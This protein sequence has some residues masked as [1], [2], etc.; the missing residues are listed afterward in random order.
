MN[1]VALFSMLFAGFFTVAEA[2]PVQ[3]R[4]RSTATATENVAGSNTV[5][6]RAATGARTAPR[7]ATSNTSATSNAVVRGRSGTTPA[8]AKPVVAARAGTTQKVV[9]TGTKVAA[10]AKNVIVSEECQA[11]YEGCMDAF[12]MLDNKSGGRCICSDK[13]AEYDAILAEIEKLDEQSLRM[14]TVGVERLEMGDDLEAAMS[15]VKD[16]TDSLEKETQKSEVTKR[17]TLD[18]SLWNSAVDFDEEIDIFGV[19]YDAIEGKE[20]DALYVA[21][22]KMCAA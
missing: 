22:D 15:M 17:R 16:V 9:S 12:C 6:A 8:T 5:A 14:G 13:N 1:R 2:A 4:G 7:T 21:A 10:A 3:R 20:G 18:L 19:N 11:K